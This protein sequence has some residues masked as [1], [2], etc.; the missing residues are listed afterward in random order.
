M[1]CAAVHEV[2][3]THMFFDDENTDMGSDAGTSTE[4]GT[5]EATPSEGEASAPAEGGDE[6]GM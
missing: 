2:R 3:R 1:L 5:G 4:E 6:A